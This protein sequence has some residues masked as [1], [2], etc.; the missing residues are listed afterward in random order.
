MELQYW[1]QQ[2]LAVDLVQGDLGPTSRKARIIDLHGVVSDAFEVAHSVPRRLQSK[3]AH[4]TGQT[5]DTSNTEKRRVM[6][7]GAVDRTWWLVVLWHDSKDV[8]IIG[9]LGCIEKL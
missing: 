8:E 4:S 7:C 1:V 2:G 9:N 6:S 5:Y 3:V